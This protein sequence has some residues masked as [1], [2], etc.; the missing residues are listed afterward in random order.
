MEELEIE[1]KKIEKFFKLWIIKSILVAIVIILILFKSGKGAFDVYFSIMGL[2]I[3]SCMIGSILLKR[4]ENKCKEKYRDYYVA[5]YL[6]KEFENVKY[7]ASRG[8][9]EVVIMKQKIVNVNYF[10][11][12]T[13]YISGT[14]KGVGFEQSN[15]RIMSSEHEADSLKMR[16]Y[17]SGVWLIL[18]F[19]RYFMSNFQIVEK[20]MYECVK[21][22]EYK[23]IT[24]GNS[25]FDNKFNVYAINSSEALDVLTFDFIEKLNKLHEAVVGKIC[26][27]F[28]DGKLH[29]GIDRGE[30]IFEFC[31]YEEN[32]EYIQR[33]VKRS[34]ELIKIAVEELML[35]EK[36]RRNKR[37]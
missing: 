19:N 21:P 11:N 33:V 14:Y 36:N 32:D 27:S 18:D 5:K 37:W 28:S 8:F 1:R 29:I 15:F 25:E 20:G 3:V 31:S 6:P 9:S 16:Y 23:K 10:N 17:F 22:D 34:M 7:D 4:K 2:F 12:K 30:R 24:V 35:Y 26:F 13:D